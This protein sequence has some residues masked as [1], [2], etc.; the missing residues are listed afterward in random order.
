[1]DDLSSDLENDDWEAPSQPMV[2]PFYLT[3]GRTE[4]TLPIEAIVVAVN[5]NRA[6]IGTEREQRAIVELCASP[7][8]IVEIA[9]HSKLPLGV[10]R[11]LVGDLVTDGRLLLSEDTSPSDLD[12][13]DR[14]IR[15]VELL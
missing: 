7:M 14:I 12:F 6:L 13:I 8:A 1:M 2:R 9:A 15:A 5:T 4:S 3:K 11:V 10:V